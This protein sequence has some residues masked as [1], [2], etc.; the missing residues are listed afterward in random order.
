MV[1][2]A[3]GGTGRDPMAVIQGTSASETLTGTAGDDTISLGGGSDQIQ[4]GAG[5]DLII[6]DSGSIST[7]D[8]GAGTDTI[9]FPSPSSLIGYLLTS[10]TLSSIER[11]DFQSE[12]GTKDSVT[13]NFGG[14]NSL[15]QPQHNQVADS[16]LASIDGGA[17]QDILS[18]FVGGGGSFTM[19]TLAKTNWTTADGP[20]ALNSDMVALRAGTSTADFTLHVSDDGSGSHSGV[21]LL[22]GSAGNDTLIGNDGIDILNG[23]GGVNVL[24]GGGGNDLL[25]AN[26]D[27]ATPN[28]TNPLGP[29]TYETLDPSV[30]DG[31]AGFD[32]LVVPTSPNL[33]IFDQRATFTSIEGVYFQQASSLTIPGL[34]SPPSTLSI[35]SVAAKTLPSNLLIDGSSGQFGISMASGDS[36][37]ASA[38]RFA[39]GSNI[40]FSILA[41]DA[42]GGQ[43][44][45]TSAADR[46]YG[47]EGHDNIMGG[48]GADTLTGGNG[49]DHLYG[50][51][52]NGGPDGADSISGD[53]GTDY[54]QGNAGNDTLDG[55]DGPD[56]INGGADNDLITGGEGADT[57]NGNLGNDS[58][59]G[60][61]GG[62][63]LR[64]GQGNDSI[65]GG[66]GDDWI[67]G[68]LGPD[69]LTGGAGRDSFAFAGQAS[70]AT[71]PD[72]ITDF[73]PDQDKLMVGFLPAAIL[74]GSSPTPANLAAIASL[75]QQLFDGHQGDHEV[76]AI[77]VG[78]DTYLFYASDGGAVADS[79]ILLQG[80]SA[81]AIGALQFG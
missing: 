37:D 31:G 3:K 10:A 55:G 25:I 9:A 32:Y 70:L 28:G 59:D 66:D 65:S 40:S 57:V 11:F 36:F 79:A 48:G 76:A 54:L 53:G 52:P 30:Y 39:P 12:S 1:C 5:D 60:G 72:M 49:N 45:A 20:A 19:P 34:V 43:I 47:G 51:S 2:P 22:Q 7:A 69:T 77:A 67:S 38:Y 15:G 24:H 44:I 71:S 8:G 75:A 26:G 68:D 21:E 46:I 13:L 81:S 50:Q 80:V 74:S 17:G 41:N 4:A 23:L 33:T 18:L 16:G 56:R 42:G 35:S 6:V 29:I 63:S 78:S 62:D 27:I 73:A 58:V 64:G 14:S 61:S